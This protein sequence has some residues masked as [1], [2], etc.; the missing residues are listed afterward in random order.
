MRFELQKNRL[1]AWCIRQARYNVA[2]LLRLLPR[3]FRTLERPTLKEFR[4][5]VRLSWT[6]QQSP[7]AKA[8]QTLSLT[9]HML[10]SH[11]R[12]PPTEQRTSRDALAPQRRAA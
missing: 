11:R 5:Y 8:K 12:T 1:F 3:E 9:R 6:I 2:D 7:Y 10:R 4:R